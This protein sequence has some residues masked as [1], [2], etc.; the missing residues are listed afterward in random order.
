MKKKLLFIIPSL[1]AGGG[2]RSLINLLSYIDYEQYEVDLHLMNHEG[3]FLELLPGEV[4]LLPLS[5]GYLRFSQPI[6]RSVADH[7]KQGELSLALNRMLFSLNNR[8]RGN[9]SVK[10]QAGWKY[11]SPSLRNLQ[12]EYD[13]AIGYLEKSSIY[14]CVDKVKAKKKIGWIHNDYDKLGMNPSFDNRYF[15]GLDHIV[16]VSEEC[17][18]VLKR[19]FPQYQHKV[20]VLYNIISPTMINNMVALTDE[21]M[22]QRKDNETVVLSIGRLHEQKNFKLAI[23]ACKELK[24]RGCSVQ[25]YVIGEGDERDQLV[26][27]INENNL[28]SNFHLLGLKTN[29]Y[30]YIAQADLY[31]QTSR[32]EGKSVAIDEAKIL[33]KPIVITNFSTAHDQLADGL[34]GIIAEMTPTAVANAI[35]EIISSETLR[36]K[37]SANLSRLSLGTEDEIN[38]LYSLI[39][40][41]ERK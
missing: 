28:T 12:H 35:E 1:A 19:R 38:K 27:L 40:R 2:E 4:N 37:F 11:V 22:Y 3:I 25:W 21:S 6:G 34:E 14:F 17:A 7:L 24:D 10:E 16:T 8:A 30:P 23:L 15:G 29:P 33:K 32:Y 9:V 13:A 41:G 26:Q 39:G 31:V 36:G 5:E 18:C 20:S